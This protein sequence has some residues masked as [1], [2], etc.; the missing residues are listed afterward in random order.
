M[1]KRDTD[2][3]KMSTL[4]KEKDMKRER[5]NGSD[6]SSIEK[7]KFKLDYTTKQEKF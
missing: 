7:P 2:I 3:R 4:L 5:N 1:S 6:F